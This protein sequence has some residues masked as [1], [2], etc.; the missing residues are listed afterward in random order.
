MI[1]IPLLVEN[2]PTIDMTFVLLTALKFTNKKWFI[3]FW[4]FLTV[5]GEPAYDKEESSD[6][7]ISNKIIEV[8]WLVSIGLDEATKFEHQCGGSLITPH[9]VLTAAHCFAYYV[10]TLPPK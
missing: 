1:S 3:S 10:D 6:S 8:P 4:L 7:Q 2:L 5:C 9:H